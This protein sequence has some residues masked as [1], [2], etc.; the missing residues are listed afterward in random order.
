MDDRPKWHFAEL[1]MRPC[2]LSQR[3][4]KCSS[5]DALATRM[6]SKYTN[7]NGMSRSTESISRWNVCAAPLRPNGIRRNSKSLN[8]VMTAVLETS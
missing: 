5:A 1:T 6:S 3:C 4:V 7:K 8:G 2:S